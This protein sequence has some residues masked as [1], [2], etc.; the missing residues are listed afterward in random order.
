M[1]VWQLHILMEYGLI[2]SRK[3][4]TW[5]PGIRHIENESQKCEP[6]WYQGKYWGLRRLPEWKDEKDLLPIGGISLTQVGKELFYL[7]KEE[8]M[9]SFTEHP[10]EGH[11][12]ALR[13]FFAE[14]GLRMAE[15]QL[16]KEL[17]T[18]AEWSILLSF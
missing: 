17:V 8:W 1:D 5:L 3:P 10:A 6:F 7:L 4:E 14:R 16:H 15:V 11:A 13:A 18:T 12:E 2:V 9:D